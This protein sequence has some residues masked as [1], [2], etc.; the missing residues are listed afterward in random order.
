[1]SPS[2]S[3]WRTTRILL[4]SDSSRRVRGDERNR[5]RRRVIT[6]RLTQVSILEIKDGWRIDRVLSNV[7][8]VCRAVLE[9]R[10]Q[11]QRLL[12]CQMSREMISPSWNAM[13]EGIVEQ[14]T[15]ISSTLHK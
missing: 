6:A 8:Q 2:W 15:G 4:M 11:I 7:R 3:C 12:H 10:P 13:K 5:I 9:S 1:M 14:M